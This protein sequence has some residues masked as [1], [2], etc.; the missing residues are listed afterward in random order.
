[1]R[2]RDRVGQWVAALALGVGLVALPAAT[3]GQTIPTS[4]PPTT[5]PPP[6]T[7][8]PTTAAPTTAAPTTEAPAETT[9]P[10]AT[11]GPPTTR[12]PAASSTTDSTVPVTTTTPEQLP[13]LPPRPEGQ[14]PAPTETTV[15]PLPDE[16]A[17][18]MSP[19]FPA[20]SVGGFTVA[21]LILVVQ[22][23]LSMRKGTGR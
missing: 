10:P 19:L 7:A 22:A 18:R 3:S 20:L 13:T 5:D 2:P 16:D 9:A 1:M 6:T 12:R 8:A 23:L 4:P 11:T 21:L 14:A 17:A 15:P